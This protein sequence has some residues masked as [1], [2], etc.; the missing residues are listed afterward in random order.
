MIFNLKLSIFEQCCPSSWDCSA[1]EERLRTPEKCFW[2]NED[3]PRGKYYEVG[4]KVPEANGHGSCR[5]ACGCAEGFGSG[6]D[7][8]C[9]MPGIYLVYQ[10]VGQA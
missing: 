9:A 3:F 1:W 10:G 8:I 5:M 6:A 4:E 2:A 7:I